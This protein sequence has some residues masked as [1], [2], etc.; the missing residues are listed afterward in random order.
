MKALIDEIMKFPPIN[1]IAKGVIDGIGKKTD[2]SSI[3]QK[4]SKFGGMVETQKK[5]LKEYFGNHVRKVFHKK[6][7]KRVM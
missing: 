1:Y 2:G 3:D 4:L 5:G 7:G 6:S